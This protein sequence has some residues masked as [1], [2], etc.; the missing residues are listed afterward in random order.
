MIGIPVNDTIA[1]KRTESLI[2]SFGRRIDYLRVSLTTACNFKCS[3]CRPSSAVNTRELIADS[4]LARL[5]GM[6]ARLGIAKVRFTG[7]EPL[8]RKEIV[9]I[10]HDISKLNGIFRIALSTN[11]YL[12]RQKLPSLVD[13]GLNG[14]NISLDSLRRDVFRRITGVDGLDRVLD[15]IDLALRCGAF[16]YVKINT[17][18]MKG[19]NDVEIPGMARWALGRKIDLRFIELM[20]A[21]GSHWSRNLYMSESEI[22][23]SIGL[24]LQEEFPR[25]NSGGP[26][27]RYTH[28]DYPGRLGFISA[29]SG[30]F[31]ASC[32]R[33]RLN[34]QGDLL[35]C[36]FK[37]GKISLK[38]LMRTGASD[39][40]IMRTVARQASRRGFRRLPKLTS[41]GD[42]EP[43]MLE[44][45]G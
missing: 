29:V 37:N 24:D 41:A 35:G 38:T 22:R 10:I 6:F 19:V 2:D 18:V 28:S 15:S 36:L 25:D 40:E 7:G 32:N 17:V 3:Y 23:K 11:G 31:C 12:L 1:S 39:E 9:R 8:L 5:I 30:N 33:I 45:G 14:V 44:T 34:S 43:S 16:E 27:R 21:R 4:E 42:F 26:A 20:P 13:A